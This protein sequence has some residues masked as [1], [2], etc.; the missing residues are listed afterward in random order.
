M[1][2]L[3]VN[4]TIFPAGEVISSKIGDTFQINLSEFDVLDMSG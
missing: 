3:L 1:M 4:V 2:R